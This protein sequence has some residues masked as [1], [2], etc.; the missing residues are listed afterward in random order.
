MKKETL[1]DIKNNVLKNLK[2]DFSRLKKPVTAGEVLG[3]SIVSALGFCLNLIG[4][5]L[6]FSPDTELIPSKL[7]GGTISLISLVISS[8]GVDIGSKSL[9]GELY[10]EKPQ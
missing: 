8:L 10:K 4:F 9:A 2:D 7:I 1:I 5:E 6:I 3:A